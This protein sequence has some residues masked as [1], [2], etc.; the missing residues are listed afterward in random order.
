M[1]SEDCAKELAETMAYVEQL[2]AF[3]MAVATPMERLVFSATYEK[4]KAKIEALR[5]MLVDITSREL[6]AEEAR[7]KADA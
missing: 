7:E 1:T 2:G 3:N 6:Y 5:H 4:A